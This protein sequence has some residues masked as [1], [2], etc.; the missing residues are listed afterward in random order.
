VINNAGILRDRSF[1]S[2]SDKE[3]DIIMAVHVRGVYACTKAA[4]M[5][6]QKQGFGRIVNVSSP[7][8]TLPL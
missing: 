8:G 6:M 5:L 7:A 4:W 2:M 1:K 3:W